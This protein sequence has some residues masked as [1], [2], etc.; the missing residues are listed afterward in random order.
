MFEASGGLPGQ[1]TLQRPTDCD[2]EEFEVV[3]DNGYLVL[4]PETCRKAESAATFPSRKPTPMC[5]LPPLPPPMIRSSSDVST[6]SQD[7]AA[8]RL[9]SSM[10]RVRYLLTH[11]LFY[12]IHE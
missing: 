6:A 10:R 5:P 9:I 1:M 3:D 11:E 2:G 4:E 7:I 8:S 12:T